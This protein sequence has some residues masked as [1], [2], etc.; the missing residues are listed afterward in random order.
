MFF[1]NT[2]AIAL[3]A[4]G[5]LP[6]IGALLMSQWA[7]GAI[8]KYGMGLFLAYS[9]AI[10]NFMA[11]SL[12]GLS[13]PA[14][15]KNIEQ[16]KS[17][18]AMGFVLSN[19]I[20]LAVFFALAYALFVG[21]FNGGAALI[22]LATGYVFVLLVESKLLW[23]ANALPQS[24]RRLRCVLTTCVVLLHALMVLLSH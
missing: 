11:G 15:P 24:Y 7:Q 5:L 6:F 8:A 21:A 22:I 13:L 9:F 17:T 4:L 1:S 20:M 2:V 3:G 14:L 18:L 12:W 10:F 16:K 19:V 23:D